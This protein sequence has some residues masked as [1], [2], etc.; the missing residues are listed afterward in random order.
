MPLEQHLTELRS[1]LIRIF[2]FWVPCFFVTYAFGTHIEKFLL[3]P[4]EVALGQGEHG[5]IVYLGILD[6]LLVQFQLSFWCSILFS[7]PYW[8]FEIWRFIKPGLY[9]NEVKVI[10]PFILIGFFLF[11]SGVLF[12]YY[13]V[14]PVVFEM[15]LQFGLS[16]IEANL[17]FK[18]YLVLSCK[19]L[20]FLG[21]MFELP[22]ILLILGFMGLVTKYSLRKMR[23]YV[24]VGMAILASLVTPPDIVTMIGIWVP[25][26]ILFEV[27]IL[28]VAF[29]VHPYLAKKYS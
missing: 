1:V 4:L 10:R 5:K 22:N 15:L 19:V 11:V 28:G 3:K 26:I 20:V 6:K 18:D 8:F 16:D 21:F 2:I 27:G 13:L 29:F 24:Y 25:L 7:S 14:F 12:G 9:K 23:S 17:S